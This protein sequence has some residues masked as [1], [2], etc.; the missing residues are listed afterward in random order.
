MPDW[1]GE[2]Q[3]QRAISAEHPKTKDQTSIPKWEFTMIM[4]NLQL[5]PPEIKASSKR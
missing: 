5:L 2:G 4:L 3:M 1:Q